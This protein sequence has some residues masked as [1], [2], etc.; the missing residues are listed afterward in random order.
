[1][2]NFAQQP[3]FLPVFQGLHNLKR[4]SILTLYHSR[5]THQKFSPPLPSLY[6]PLLPSLVTIDYESVKLD[7]PRWI[8]LTSFPTLES[9]RVKF[10]AWSGPD[11]LVVDENNVGVLRHIEI[12]APLN[13]I[14]TPFLPSLANAP[15][16]NLELHPELSCA[17]NI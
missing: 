12:E 2:L 6:P 11:P 16:E 13:D 5:S 4:L 14:A 3:Q 10:S 15:C 17:A 9:L 1:M 8:F 7:Q